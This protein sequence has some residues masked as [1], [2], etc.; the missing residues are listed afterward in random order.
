MFQAQTNVSCDTFLVSFNRVYK[1]RFFWKNRK[2]CVCNYARLLH[3]E[4][5]AFIEPT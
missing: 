2:R 1:Q 5:K 4:S 3:T